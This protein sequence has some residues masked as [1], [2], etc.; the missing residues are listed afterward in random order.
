MLSHKLKSY[1]L[2]SAL[3]LSPV[4]ALAANTSSTSVVNTPTI[5]LAGATLMSFKSVPG[6]A[7]GQDAGGFALG[8]M[9]GT[10]A[11]VAIAAALAVAIA[12]LTGGDSTTTSSSTSTGTNTATGTVWSSERPEWC[13]C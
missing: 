4:T 13:N 10:A 7:A 5:S 3:V 11:A 9:G 8:Q 1:A 12:A 6:A 2:A